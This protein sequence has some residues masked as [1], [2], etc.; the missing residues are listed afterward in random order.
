M[1]IDVIGICHACTR[2]KAT[3]RA[4]LCSR[5]IV[6]AISLV[7]LLISAVSMLKNENGFIFLAKNVARISPDASTTNVNIAFLEDVAR[8]PS[9]R[10][11]NEAS[12]A[13][14]IAFLDDV[15]RLV[16]AYVSLVLYLVLKAATGVGPISAHYAT[17]LLTSCLGCIV[18]FWLGGWAEAVIRVV[19]AVALIS[20][21]NQYWTGTTPPLRLLFL[22]AV[23]CMLITVLYLA[24]PLSSA[25]AITE[26]LLIVPLMFGEVLVTVSC[27][28]AAITIRSKDGKPLLSLLLAMNA[29]L[30]S[31]INNA[32]SLHFLTS[33][34]DLVFISRLLDVFVVLPCLIP[35]LL[36]MDKDEAQELGQGASHAMR[37][38]VCVVLV[39]ALAILSGAAEKTLAQLENPSFCDPSLECTSS[40][41]GRTC[42]GRILQDLD[43]PTAYTFGIIKSHM[44]EARS[45]VCGRVQPHLLDPV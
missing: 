39:L 40:D 12:T 20:T 44:I 26:R 21:A 42:A 43:M 16:F 38:R 27:T 8:L 5:V 23:S 35:G 33:R 14:N 28:H 11:P 37:T 34:P 9:S 1:D 17:Y 2:H 31:L 15:V 25:Q 18:Y 22:G 19:S 6:L 4:T 29:C 3:S 36:R 41:F 32:F 7:L 10:G 24:L 13:F 45:C 30:F